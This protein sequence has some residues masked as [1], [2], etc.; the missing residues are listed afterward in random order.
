MADGSRQVAIISPVRPPRAKLLKLKLTKL[1]S[2]SSRAGDG[3]RVI[4]N[5]SKAHRHEKWDTHDK[6]GVERD[7]RESRES[8][9]G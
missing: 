9:D 2:T 6:V 8:G 7:K 1:D 3:S 5:E 4:N